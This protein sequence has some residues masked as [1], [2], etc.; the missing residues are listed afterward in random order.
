[1]SKVY[2]L[3]YCERTYCGYCFG[4]GS[5][6]YRMKCDNMKA[7]DY[8][9]LMLTGW[10][11][12]GKSYSCPDNSSSCCKLIPIRCI[13]EDFTLSK[14]QKKVVKKFNNFLK[15]EP[16]NL[17][18]TQNKKQKENQKIPEELKKKIQISIIKSLEGICEYSENLSKIVCNRPDRIE[19]YG[20][21]SLSTCISISAK[22]PDFDKNSILQ[23]LIAYISLELSNTQ[24]SIFN[25][26][27]Y[28]INLKDSNILSNPA[29]DIQ[30][31][32]KK[33][34]N[35]TYS[36]EIVPADYRQSSFELYKEYV[37]TRH[38]KIPENVTPERYENFLCGKNLI[39]EEPSELHP[40]GL[41][42][43]HQLHYIDG[44]LVAVGVLDFVPSG[45]VSMYFFYSP[46][47][48]FLSLGVLSAI[49]EIG[50][51]KD[52][53]TSSFRY[54]YMAWFIYDC[55]KMNYKDKYLPS[56]LLCPT[57]YVWVDAKK[58]LKDPFS[59]GFYSLHQC[60]EETFGK[61]NEDTDWSDVDFYSFLN[62]HLKIEKSQEIINFGVYFGNDRNM[63][64]MVMMELKQFM[65][66]SM[67]KR[68][69][70]RFD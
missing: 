23:I 52:N 4:D 24:W 50:L 45:V 63:I 22:N 33:I 25:T 47:Y 65:S 60:S 43:F 9:S 56:Q 20:H 12:N 57:N 54:Y 8:D 49:W 40:L 2:D 36:S 3:R 66:K 53:I 37:V 27:N 18:K 42:N 16:S 38:D 59:H 64:T 7:D 48:M 35:H 62:E 67:M 15:S 46:K 44:K 70:F 17:R 6:K 69:I 11:R 29:P 51:V 39:Q 31:S 5:N 21:Y 61:V 68:L 10:F 13:V 58:C 34:Q 41:G 26:N 19:I 1:M 32:H 30:K 14:S 28:Y 55:V